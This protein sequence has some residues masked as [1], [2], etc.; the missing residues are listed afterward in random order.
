MSDTSDWNGP[1]HLFY[2][3]ARRQLRL[4]QAVAYFDAKD[5]GSFIDDAP[6]LPI[7]GRQG[8]D[9]FDLDEGKRC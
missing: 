4:L 3:Q 1:L 8:L 2:L 7:N 6:F 9:L 5:P